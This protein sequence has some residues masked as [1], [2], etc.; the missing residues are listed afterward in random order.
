MQVHTID[1]PSITDI[2]KLSE[3]VCNLENES[4]TICP[5]IM[6]QINN[7]KIKFIKKYLVLLS[8]V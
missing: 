8:V 4:E 2:L 3:F 6:S 1:N 7:Q 5:E